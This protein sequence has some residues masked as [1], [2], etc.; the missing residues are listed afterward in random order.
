MVWGS[1]F[2]IDHLHRDLALDKNDDIYVTWG[3]HKGKDDPSHWDTWMKPEWNAK[4]FLPKPLGDRDCGAAKIASDGS[5]VVWATYMG[6]SG[7]DSVEGSIRVDDKGC[8]YVC[9]YSFS[10]DLP[11]TEGAFSKTNSGGAD[12]YVAKVKPDG[13]DIIYGTYIG[14]EGDNW[15]NTHNLAIDSEGN[16]YTSTCAFS[17]SFPTTPDA[18]QRV[19]GGKVDWGI[20]KFSPTGGLAAST[21]FGGS[22]GDN[23]DGIRIDKDGNLVVFGQS[24][25]ADFRVSKDAYQSKKSGADDAVVV[26]FSPNL[27]RILYAT[28]LGGD[29]NDAGRAGCVDKDGNLIVAGSSAGGTFPLKAAWQNECRGPGDAIIAK[30]AVKDKD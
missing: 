14:D 6:G 27:D 29:K 15:L 20:V 1:F 11:T 10:T 2:G 3:V 26:K 28:F 12:W 21:L 5:K 30:F 19:H 4:A 17:S 9:F 24:G 25:S 16:C 23:P 18:V 22:G 13:S 7:A 8:P